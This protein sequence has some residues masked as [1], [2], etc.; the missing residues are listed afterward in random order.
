MSPLLHAA[1]ALS[2]FFGLA[3]AMRPVTVLGALIFRPALL[4]A[5]GLAGAGALAS[6]PDTMATPSPALT[7][8]LGAVA[9]GGLTGLLLRSL[10]RGGT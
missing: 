1:W 2:F 5:V 10:F 8:G 3:L 9:L 7:A 6:L 4:G